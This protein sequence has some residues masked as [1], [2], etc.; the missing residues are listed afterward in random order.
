MVMKLNNHTESYENAKKNYA[1]VVKNESSTPEQIETAWSEMQD[2]LVNSLS[3]QIKE[4]VT[5]DNLDNM[6]LTSRGTNVLTTEERTFFNAVVQSDGFTSNVILP[7]TVVE[8]I[9]EELTADHPLLSVINFRNLGTITLTA[10]TS[11]YEGAAVWGPIF[12]DIKGQLDAAFKQENIAQ[13]KLTAFVVLPKD[14]KKFG[15]TWVEAYVRAQITETY[16][17]ALENAIINGAGPTKHEPIGLIRDLAAAVDP[18]NGHAKKAAQSTLTLADSQTTIKEFAAIGKLLS[19]K[20]NGKPLN[21]SGK[22]VL[23]I[24]P[25]DAWD[26]K[27]KFTTQNS[28][29]VYITALPFNFTLVESVFATSGEVIAFVKDRY[30]AYRGG[31]VEVKE[32]E[33]T[34]AI[35]D[36]NL[37]VAKTFA[38]GKPRDNKVAAIYTLSIT[39]TTTTTAAV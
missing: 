34:L 36:C 9:Y 25:E 6:V 7:E 15:P 35:E 4:Q 5:N 37:H 10:I 20:E 1:A 29:G 8:R 2:A 39:T 38:F 18:T 3:T 17:V 28:L 16:A 13:S 21:V 30:D 12:G 22:V 32:Y 19:K 11:E 23:I 24:N 31:G 26:L 33:Q 14:L 27:A